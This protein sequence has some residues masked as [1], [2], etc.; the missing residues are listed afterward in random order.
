MASLFAHAVGTASAFVACMLLIAWTSRCVNNPP[1]P[2]CCAVG[3]YDDLRTAIRERD[4]AVLAVHG[5]KEQN[6]AAPATLLPASS[7]SQQEVAATAVK[8]Q[9]RVRGAWCIVHSTPCFVGGCRIACQSWWAAG[10]GLYLGRELKNPAVCVSVPHKAGSQWVRHTSCSTL[11]EFQDRSTLLCRLSP[12]GQ[13]RKKACACAT[14][15]VG[16]CAAY[17]RL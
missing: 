7:Y 1:C 4:L 6:A 14:V 11:R 13:L 2:C 5:R 9:K 10:C 17:R 12:V 8:L 15:I 16:R 3:M